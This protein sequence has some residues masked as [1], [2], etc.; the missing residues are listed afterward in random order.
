MKCHNTDKKHNPMKHML[1]MILCCGLPMLIIFTLPFIAKVSPAAAGILGLISPFICP[2]M[3]G[4]MLFFMFR[5]DK[6]SCCEEKKKEISV[7]QE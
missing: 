1:H 6:A 7:N 2:I 4:G 5:K 3:M